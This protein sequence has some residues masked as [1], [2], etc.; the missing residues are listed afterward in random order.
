MNRIA[1]S[2]IFA[3]GMVASASAA[4]I[5]RSGGPAGVDNRVIAGAVNADG[6]VVSGSGFTAEE[7]S[8]G[9]YQIT[10]TD[11][12]FLRGCPIVVASAEEPGTAAN[13][14]PGPC[15]KPVIIETYFTGGRNASYFTF[16][17]RDTAYDP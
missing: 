4:S 10:F 2:L 9:Q 11:K 17:A 7:L 6:S 1:I 16:I 3:V 12:E 8:A 14:F 5:F 13:V 15:R